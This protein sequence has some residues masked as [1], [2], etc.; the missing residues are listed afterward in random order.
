MDQEDSNLVVAKMYDSLRAI[1]GLSEDTM[2]RAYDT[3]MV[4]TMRAKDFLRMSD[5]ERVKY[6]LLN[7]G[8]L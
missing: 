2:I 7:Y 4:E 3:F 6:I 1:L 8:G 5:S